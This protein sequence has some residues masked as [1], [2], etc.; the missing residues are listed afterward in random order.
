MK[1]RKT[2]DVNFKVATPE[3]FHPGYKYRLA[4][5]VSIVKDYNPDIEDEPGLAVAFEKV[6][7]R[8]HLITWGLF[9]TKDQI[10]ASKGKYAGRHFICIGQRVG[11]NRTEPLFE[12]VVEQ[13]N[14]EW[15]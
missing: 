13:E 9:L 8:V 3:G 14:L 4:F 6:N 5:A 11:N 7:G 10:T 12:M 1:I 15:R 2:I